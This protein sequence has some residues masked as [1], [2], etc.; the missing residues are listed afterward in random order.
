MQT[1]PGI[2]WLSEKTGSD[3][4]TVKKTRRSAAEA[5]RCRF[6]RVETSGA[7][8]CHLRYALGYWGTRHALCD[9]SNHRSPRFS[10][11]PDSKVGAVT[12]APAFDLP[13]TALPGSKPRPN[14]V[15]AD[16]LRMS[17]RFIVLLPVAQ[18]MPPINPH[19][20]AHRV[21]GR[22]PGSGWRRGSL[23]IRQSKIRQHSPRHNQKCS[24]IAGH[25]FV[26]LNSQ[27]VSWDS[28]CR[29]AQLVTEH[30]MD[31]KSRFYAH[32]FMRRERARLPSSGTRYATRAV[33]RGAEPLSADGFLRT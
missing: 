15:I 32:E 6:R 29:G 33:R 13:T 25:Y 20:I 12:A 26:A 14:A 2:V 30:S 27:I 31:S 16:R 17:R 7:V 21:C 9:T 10:K 4:G 5:A 1:G 8:Q 19:R 18:Y 28:T 11:T 23:R 24:E 22:R 3:R